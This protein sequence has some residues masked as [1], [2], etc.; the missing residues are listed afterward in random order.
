MKGFDPT[1]CSIC[2]R[3]QTA[4]IILGVHIEAKKLFKMFA[5]LQKSETNLP[6]TRRGGIVGSF[7]L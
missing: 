6:S 2:K 3:R 5:F 4:C 1:P 7:L